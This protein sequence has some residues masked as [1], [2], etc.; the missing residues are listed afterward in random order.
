MKI[1]PYF[2]IEQE[3]YSVHQIEHEWGSRLLNELLRKR[4]CSEIS[5]EHGRKHLSFEYVGITAYEGKM[6]CVLPK[7]YSLGGLGGKLL[8]EMVLVLKVIKKY[9]SSTSVQGEGR[10]LHYDDVE[11]SGMIALADYILDDYSKY[12]YYYQEEL[13]LVLNGEGETHW[14]KTIEQC[15]PVFAGRTPVYFDAYAVD[16]S[17][18]KD[19]LIINLHKYAVYV[20][21]RYFGELLDYCIPGIDDSVQDLSSLGSVEDLTVLV[22]R[23]LSVTYSDQKTG[24]LKALLSF[25]NNHAQFDSQMMLYGTRH[26]ETIW[27]EVC[28]SVLRNEY[29]NYADRIP[30]PAWMIYPGS[31]PVRKHTYNPDI[32]RTTS[33]L[34]ENLF[35]IMDA[36][37]YGIKFENGR[38]TGNPGVED[39]SKQLLYD[40]AL[41]EAQAGFPRR[42]NLFL[43]PSMQEEAVTPFGYVNLEFLHR[44]P[45]HL[46]YVSSHHMFAMYLTGA[47]LSDREVDVIAERIEAAY[48]ESVRNAAVTRSPTLIP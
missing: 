6:I 28:G 25:L 17:I 43:F 13:R 40:Q 24:Q 36:K 46:L 3:R 9:S 47:A 27:E 29:G 32:I 14:Q 33:T 45:V 11:E 41:Q 39:V 30:K 20:C 38:L 1:A 5:G 12:G 15:E 7:H 42:L 31:E 21:D 23:E 8:S 48:A 26:F 18:I 22:E 44:S 16:S 19:H 4:L 2:F 34:E 10:Y 35:L 37:Y